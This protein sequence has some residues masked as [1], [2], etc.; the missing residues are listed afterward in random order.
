MMGNIIVSENMYFG[1][2]TKKMK[3]CIHYFWSN[4][5]EK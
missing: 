1:I 5:K 3:K 2:L 4:R